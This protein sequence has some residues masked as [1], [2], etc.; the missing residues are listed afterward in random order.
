MGMPQQPV[1]PQAVS[2]SMF[3]MG[4]SRYNNQNNITVVW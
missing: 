1:F 2:F 3:T 4:I